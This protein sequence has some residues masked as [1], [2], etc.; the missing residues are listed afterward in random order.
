M[1][2]L[3]EI[4]HRHNLRKITDAP[5]VNIL[6]P[7]QAAN[8]MELALELIDWQKDLLRDVALYLRANF[9]Q[10]DEVYI[11]LINRIGQASE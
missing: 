8:D 1:T 5:L 7:N 9:K 10:N 2:M 6:G 11:D 3:A 4:K